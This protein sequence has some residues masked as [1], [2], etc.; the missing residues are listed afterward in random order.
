MEIKMI[1]LAAWVMVVSLWVSS[2]ALAQENRPIVLS[3]RIQQMAAEFPV[4]ERLGIK[5]GS[6]SPEDIGRYIGFLAAA[7][8]IAITIA[9][10]ND[11]KIPS[12]ADYQASFAALCIWP[13]NKPPLAEPDWQNAFA[14]FDNQN[15]RR[16]LQEAVGPLA[17]S[18]PKEI[19]AGEGEKAVLEKW[20]TSNEGYWGS[21]L[22]LKDLPK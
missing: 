14:A 21:V 8:Q 6:A 5:W 20:P 1:R 10:K 19:D 9:E 13:P 16:A 11:R 12:D 18:L 17:V 4:A 7:N 3:E 22:N 2:M 15:V